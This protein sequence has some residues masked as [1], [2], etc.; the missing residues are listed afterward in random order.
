MISLQHFVGS[1]S[2]I[3]SFYTSVTGLL[4]RFTKGPRIVFVVVELKLDSNLSV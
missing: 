4:L 1:S 2:R 3:L